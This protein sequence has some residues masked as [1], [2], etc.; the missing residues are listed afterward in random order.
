MNPVEYAPSRRKAK[1]MNCEANGEQNRIDDKG[2]R[3]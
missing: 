2:S 3:E 1:E